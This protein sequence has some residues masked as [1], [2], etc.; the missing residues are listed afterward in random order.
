[1]QAGQ[2]DVRVVDLERDRLVHDPCV[3]WSSS[4]LFGSR[5]CPFEEEASDFRLERSAF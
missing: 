5:L 1:V 2:R 4:R 3:V